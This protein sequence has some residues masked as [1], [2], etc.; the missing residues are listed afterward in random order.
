MDLE[1]VTDLCKGQEM[2]E[3]EMRSMSIG[4]IF[5]RAARNKDDPFHELRAL[6]RIE[7]NY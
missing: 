7:D 6:E 3:Q 2:S 5:R 4:S 1:W